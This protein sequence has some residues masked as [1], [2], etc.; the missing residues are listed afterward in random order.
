VKRLDEQIHLKYAL[1][2]RSD[3]S[4][5]AFSAR[6]LRTLAQRFHLW[7]PSLRTFSAPEHFH[8]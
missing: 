1:E 3:I 6:L 7:L 8:S 2:A 5:R 4:G